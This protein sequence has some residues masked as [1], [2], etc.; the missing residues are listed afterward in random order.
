MRRSALENA[1][2][3]FGQV[4][5]RSIGGVLASRM[6]RTCVAVPERDQARGERAVEQARGER[7]EARGSRGEALLDKPAVA[8]EGEA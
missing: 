3:V 6:L 5:S 1:R 4:P 2:A 7:P 8:P